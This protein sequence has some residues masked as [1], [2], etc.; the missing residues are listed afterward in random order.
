MN[1][2][3]CVQ[4]EPLQQCRRKSGTRAHWSVQAVSC[5]RAALTGPSLAPRAEG[6][7]GGGQKPLS[8]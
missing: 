2:G 5:V 8:G 6:V 4:P 7:G 1:G 3:F